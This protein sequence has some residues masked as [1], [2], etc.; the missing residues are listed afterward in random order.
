M[1]EQDFQALVTTDQGGGLVVLF[2]DSLGGMAALDVMSGEHKWTVKGTAASSKSA[3]VA[4]LSSQA[5]GGDEYFFHAYSI[6]ASV[7]EAANVASW[8]AAPKLR[9][10]D[11]NASMHASDYAP[12]TVEKRSLKDGSLVWKKERVA[13]VKYGWFEMEVSVD[14][15]L[16]YLWPGVEGAWV[17]ALDASD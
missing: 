2:G 6:F 9:H 16:V 5:Q 13:H 12:I 8:S 10:G 4:F 17:A 1:V 14:G 15:S 3:Q 7:E 11:R